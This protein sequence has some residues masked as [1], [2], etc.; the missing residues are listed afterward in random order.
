[1]I[2][3]AL[4][5]ISSASATRVTVASQ[6]NDHSVAESRHIKEPPKQ[7]LN[8]SLNTARDGPVSLVVG[9]APV[10][11]PSH[12]WKAPREILPV[13]RPWLAAAY[14]GCTVP[15]I[16]KKPFRL[17]SSGFKVGGLD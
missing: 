4:G 17:Q 7:A 13:N 11:G 2:A 9:R 16:D 8:G 5:W 15:R 10:L 3:D 12:I 1:M 6:T 14:A